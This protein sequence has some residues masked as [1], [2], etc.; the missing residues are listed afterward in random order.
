MAP[1]RLGGPIWGYGTGSYGFSAY[2]EGKAPPKIELMMQVV[3]TLGERVPEG[4]LI[5]A[6]TLPWFKIVEA[7][8]RDSS[9]MHEP[10]WRKWEELIAGLIKLTDGKS[11]LRHAAEIRVVT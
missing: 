1:A 9:L 6:V 8:T 11:F 10:D 7:I 3:V 4:H 2:G 5:E